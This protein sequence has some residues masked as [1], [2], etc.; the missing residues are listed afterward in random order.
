MEL[1]SINFTLNKNEEY[2][3]IENLITFSIEKQK[4]SLG[5]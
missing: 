5:Q 3:I 4:D 1:L 2:L